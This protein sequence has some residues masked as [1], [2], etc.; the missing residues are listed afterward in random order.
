M[1]YKKKKKLD[2]RKL[3]TNYLWSKESKSSSWKFL[4][5]ENPL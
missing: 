2:S 4:V 1:S 3:D 5:A